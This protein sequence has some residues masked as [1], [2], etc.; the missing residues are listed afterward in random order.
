MTWRQTGRTI[1]L[2]EQHTMNTRTFQ[3]SL[4]L[5]IGAG[6]AWAQTGSAAV[7]ASVLRPL[8]LSARK[9]QSPAV[10]AAA[11]PT[12]QAQQKRQPVSAGVD[13]ATESPETVLLPYGAGYDSRQRNG[14]ADAGNAGGAG[15]GSGGRGGGGG[16]GGG[17][18]GGR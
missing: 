15:S 6:G 8:N 16:S 14:G 13:G 2:P 1:H 4:L 7:D 17:G 3:L 18:R 5:M 11:A 12:E 10:A 9:P